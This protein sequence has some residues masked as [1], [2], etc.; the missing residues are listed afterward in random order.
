ML[1]TGANSV[2]HHGYGM[3]TVANRSVGQI[4]ATQPAH[5]RAHRFDEMR[6]IRRLGQH[7]TG[8][9]RMR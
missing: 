3:I 9:T 4:R 8:A 2:A 5:H 1:A 7:P 6:L